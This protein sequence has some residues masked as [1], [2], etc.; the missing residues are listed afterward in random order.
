[1]QCR[2]VALAP[3]V[4]ELHFLLGQQNMAGTVSEFSVCWKGVTGWI[5]GHQL[6]PDVVIVSHS[7][8]QGLLGQVKS[9]IVLPSHVVSG[10]AVFWACWGPWERVSL[11]LCEGIQ[12]FL[13]QLF[14]GKSPGRLLTLGALFSEPLTAF[15][16]LVCMLKNRSFQK[17]IRKKARFLQ[18]LGEAANAGFRRFLSWTK[19]ALWRSRGSVGRVLISVDG[20]RNT[21]RHVISRRL[22][23]S[24]GLD[25]VIPSALGHS[26][27]NG[28][29]WWSI[30]EEQAHRT[31]LIAWQLSIASHSCSHQSNCR[32]WPRSVDWLDWAR[33]EGLRTHT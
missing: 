15:W 12:A 8:T 11:P 16:F 24:D 1:M 9:R 22:P 30:E 10:P 18:R 26:Y 33:H 6:L 31:V 7:G 20:L 17:K 25:L 3:E 2:V 29:H 14:N 32:W 23:P 19:V 28:W 21:R 5:K 13:G 27:T 4:A